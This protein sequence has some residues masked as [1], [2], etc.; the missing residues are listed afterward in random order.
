LANKGPENGVFKAVKK[1]IRKKG[2]ASK[3]IGF[4]WRRKSTKGK[5][6][7]KS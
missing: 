5:P 4:I 7:C 1:W 6:P 2:V 3:M